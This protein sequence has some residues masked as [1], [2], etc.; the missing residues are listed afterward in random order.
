MLVVLGLVCG[1]G[2]ADRAGQVGRDAAQVK[3]YVVAVTFD[4]AIARLV[5]RVV[6]GSIVLRAWAVAPLVYVQPV[7]FRPEDRGELIG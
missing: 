7:G 2:A 4:V 5:A 3:G 6:N 1:D